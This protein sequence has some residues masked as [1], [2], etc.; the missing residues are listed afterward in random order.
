MAWTAFW[1]ETPKGAA[2]F[3]SCSWKS[4]WDLETMLSGIDEDVLLLIYYE[5]KPSRSLGRP[6]LQVILI[7]EADAHFLIFNTPPLR[8]AISFLNKFFTKSSPFPGVKSK[9]TS[10]FCS[11]NVPTRCNCNCVPFWQSLANRP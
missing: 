1:H 8:S 10:T 11:A 9:E 5:Q 4:W 2:D 6:S 3:T 7:K